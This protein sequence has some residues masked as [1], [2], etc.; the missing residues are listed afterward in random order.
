[1]IRSG[2]KDDSLDLSQI[3][4]QMFTLANTTSP[5]LSAQPV[6]DSGI[7]NDLNKLNYIIKLI[8]R[9]DWISACFY[10][11]GHIFVCR[12]IFFISFLRHIYYFLNNLIRNY[13]VI[14]VQMELLCQWQLLR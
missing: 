5:A 10:Y 9:R 13:M 6:A 8:F 1:M 11:S 4:R 2:L 12:F 14:A 7:Q 3:W